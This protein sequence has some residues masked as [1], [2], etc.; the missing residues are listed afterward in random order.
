MLAKQSIGTRLV[1]LQIFTLL[2]FSIAFA[3]MFWWSNQQLDGLIDNRLASFNN[4]LSKVIHRNSQP[5]A[6]VATDY[7]L[8]DEMIANIDSPD[9]GWLQV[10]IDESVPTF[11]V[12]HAWILNPS[13]QQIYRFAAQPQHINMPFSL[14]KLQAMN[15]R[16][17][18]H[19]FYNYKTGETWAVAEFHAM[20]V[21]TSDDLQRQGPVYG[22]LVVAWTLGAQHLSE[23]GEQLGASIS[24][25]PPESQ[26]ELA[27]SKWI[28]NASY[29]LKGVDNQSQAAVISARQDI[30]DLQQISQAILGAF[31][32]SLLALL[33]FVITSYSFL[34]SIIIRP[35]KAMSKALDRNSIEPITPYVKQ[36]N[37]IGRLSHLILQFYK[38]RQNLAQDVKQKELEIQDM[39]Y[40]NQSL[41][42]DSRTDQLTQLCN[43]RG[44]DEYFERCWHNAYNDKSSLAII[45]IDIDLFKAY[46]DYYGH[47]Q[48]D[49]ALTQVA[50]IMDVSVMRKHDLLARYGGEEFV[51]MCP[52]TD[53][54]GAV[55]LAENIRKAIFDADI[56][57]IKSPPHQ[58]LTISLG[59]AS[60]YPG[61]GT[62]KTRDLLLTQADQC[63]YKAKEK[64]RNRLV[65][66]KTLLSQNELSA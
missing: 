42:L 15:N 4:S 22:W 12:E 56:E 55:T 64:G 17:G 41:F 40:A 47:Q 25:Q 7:S 3:T 39:E 65:C 51:V 28:L 49:E 32:I 61:T 24:L 11:G 53:I 52:H 50:A 37:E 9:T 16:E 2:F 5:L 43:R 13:G 34:N 60:M 29:P 10:N 66:A 44:F 27:T 45:L 48:G 8:W 36:R 62:G 19:G 18:L 20:P 30:T 14:D 1:I 54:S 58:R 31:V 23:I 6:A 46:N 63:L 33:L 26:D 35:I 59:V 57:H 38:Q 21:Q